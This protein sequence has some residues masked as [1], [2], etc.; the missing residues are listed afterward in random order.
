[1]T[2]SADE[3]PLGNDFVFRLPSSPSANKQISSVALLT[4]IP[5]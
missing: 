2:A 3:M 1:M 4:S 5:T